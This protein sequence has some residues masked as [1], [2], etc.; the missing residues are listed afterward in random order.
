MNIDMRHLRTG[1]YVNTDGVESYTNP[2]VVGKAMNGDLSLDYDSTTL[3]GD[4]AD[5][6]PKAVI[7]GKLKIGTTRLP[8]PVRALFGGH[9]YVPAVTG[10]TPAPAKMVVNDEDEANEVGFGY[11][12][13]EMDDVKAKHYYAVFIP[14]I[15][16]GSPS[17]A[18]K[19]KAKA[20]E[21]QTPTLEGELLANVSGDFYEET[22]HA[23]FAAA[24]TYINAKLGFVE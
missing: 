14:R 13:A 12:Y 10:D 20:T 19:T 21:Y 7:G 5:Q 24:L 17:D 15:I 9:T 22:E 11:C 3:F 6:A 4:S 16:F 1:K 18:Y 2:A 23:S 8:K